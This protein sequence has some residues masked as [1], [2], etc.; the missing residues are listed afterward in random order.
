MLAL[1]KHQYAHT[2]KSFA[3]ECLS[4]TCSRII[5]GSP[6]RDLITIVR[7]NSTKL[8]ERPIAHW[9][10]APL[11]CLNFL[12]F[13]K[14]RNSIVEEKICHVDGGPREGTKIGMSSV[15]TGSLSSLLAGSIGDI[16]T[17]PSIPS[18]VL[19]A[20]SPVFS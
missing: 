10:K 5:S 13:T 2:H 1:K 15:L 19:G 6:T 14:V 18:T 20:V 8:M 17:S 16:S 11:L 4:L 12:F 3:R 7:S 9:A